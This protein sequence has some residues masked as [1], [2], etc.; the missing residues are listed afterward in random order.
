M[1]VGA[2]CRW[3]GTRTRGLGSS[4]GEPWLVFFSTKV[5]A[6]VGT[7][8]DQPSGQTR[9]IWIS[10]LWYGMVWGMWEYKYHIN[11]TLV[12]FVSWMVSMTGVET[13]PNVGKNNGM[14]MNSPSVG[15]E[16][17]VLII[18]VFADGGWG[19]PWEVGE[20]RVCWEDV[21]SSYV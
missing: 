6:L 1:H 2:F 9:S 8:W 7:K 18:L 19:N 17:K 20:S 21:E 14:L 16:G 10:I 11:N 12:R 4:G 3:G 5:L 13:M 15:W